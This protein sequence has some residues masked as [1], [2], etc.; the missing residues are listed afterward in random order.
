MA[1]S[2][3]MCRGSKMTAMNRHARLK[4]EISH[5]PVN[6]MRQESVVLCLKKRKLASSELKGKNIDP[7]KPTLSRNS[8]STARWSSG[9]NWPNQ[10]NYEIKRLHLQHRWRNRKRTC[11][12][13]SRYSCKGTGRA[14]Q[15]TD[16]KTPLRTGG[17][18]TNR[19]M[20]EKI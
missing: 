18:R 13:L 19:N 4:R 16:S 11:G 3:C 9:S 17:Q 12:E 1:A 20:A 2:A 10:S 8:R 15:R 5:K 7:Y 14:Q 6:R